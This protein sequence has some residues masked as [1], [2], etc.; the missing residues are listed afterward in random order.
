[1]TQPVR[2]HVCALEP[3]RRY[4]L[5]L[6]YWARFTV[7]Q[8]ER[9]QEDFKVPYKGA[10]PHPLPRSRT[11]DVNVTERGKRSPIHNPGLLR[12]AWVITDLKHFQGSTSLT[13]LFIV[14]FH[15]G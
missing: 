8:R 6:F 12:S 7:A 5:W 14:T 15:R 2:F 9:A 4:G 1:M 13:R 10:L 3:Q 11:K